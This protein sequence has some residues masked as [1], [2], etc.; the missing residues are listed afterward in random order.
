MRQRRWL[1]LV[2][3][4]DCNIS[5][6]PGKANVV[7]DALSRKSSGSLAALHELEKTLQ[8]DLCRSG[9]ELITGRLSAMTLQS[10][11]LD[12]IIQGQKEDPELIGH[13]ELVESRK[14]SDFSISTEGVIRF[15]G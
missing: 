4:Y 8:E 13:K 7:A 11:L 9:I 2:K 5:Y 1:E 10:T 6:H 15:Q 3:D 14:E 12:R